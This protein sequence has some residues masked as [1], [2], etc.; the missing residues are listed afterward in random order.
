MSGKVVLMKM[1]KD[2]PIF[3][4]L[5]VNIDSRFL[6]DY[7]RIGWKFHHIDESSKGNSVSK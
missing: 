4:K 1:I 3:L 2:S 6:E 5:N 7:K